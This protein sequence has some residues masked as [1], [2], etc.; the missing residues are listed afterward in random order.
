MDVKDMA[1]VK[2]Q[3]KPAPLPAE[4]AL[5]GT[6]QQKTPYAGIYTGPVF[7]MARTQ[8]S[9]VADY[10]AIPED[11]RAR[12]LYPKRAVTVSCPIHRDD[13]SLA[14]YE[15]YRV[16][17]HL[18]LGPTKG[19]TRFSLS[20]DIGEVAAL[21]IWMSWKCALSGLPYGGAKGGITVDPQALSA[22]ELESLSRR[23]MQEMIPFVGPHVDVMA[24]DMG[25]NEQVMAWFMDTYSMYQGQTVTEIVTGKP[26]SAGGTLGRRE[27]TGRGVAY[28]VDRAMQRLQMHPAGATAIVQGFGNVGSIAAIE[29]GKRGVKIIGVSDH[30]A[31]YFDPRGLDVAALVRHAAGHGGVLAGFSRE[32]AFDPNELLVQPCDVLVPAAHERVITEKNAGK[33]HCRILAEAAN[34]PTTPEADGVLNERGK[35]IFLIPDILC[36]AGGVIV[37]YFEWVQDLQQFFWEEAEVMNR[38]NHVLGKAFDQVMARVER[39]GSPHRTAAMAIGVEKVRNAKKVRGLFP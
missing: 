9:V 10:L 14:V 15:G 2:N 38:M 20:V 30:T 5:G 1:N 4:K 3:T 8:F 26:V 17:H 35:D 18:T 33:L 22:R 29:L 12:I 23:Y 7:E 11:E 6:P 28:L 13:G 16:Q 31:C 19:G 24:P 25:T 32:L 34:G 27:A 37:S 21:A 36:N 39:D